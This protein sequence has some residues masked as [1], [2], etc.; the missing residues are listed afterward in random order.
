MLKIF[1]WNIYQL[2][3]SNWFQS[4]NCSEFIEIWNIWYFK[5]GDL[6]FNVKNNF[7]KIFTTYHALQVNPKI[8]NTQNLLKFGAFDISNIP[9][10]VLISKILFIKYLPPGRPKLV[11]K[12]KMIRIYWNLEH[13]IFQIYQSRFWS[14]KAFLLNHLIIRLN[15]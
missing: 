10:L 6:D 12:L 8:K 9:V 14:R 15:Y 11:P 1:F 7:Y 2:L 3:G 13:L 5:Y 4:K